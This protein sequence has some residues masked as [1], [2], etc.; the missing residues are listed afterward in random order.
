MNEK[1][2][3]LALILIVVGSVLAIFNHSVCY[4]LAPIGGAILLGMHEIAEK[5]K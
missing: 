4:S 5:I 1:T 2:F 3:Y